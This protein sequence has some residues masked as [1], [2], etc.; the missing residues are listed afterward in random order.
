M[1]PLNRRRLAS[2][3][4]LALLMGMLGGC[5]GDPL[6]WLPESASPEADEVDE[7]IYLIIYVTGVVFLAVQGLLIWFLFRHRRKE[8]V[9]AK[10]THGN[11]TI[12]MVWTIAPALVL[13]LLAVYQADL[14]VRLK[15]KVP[16][17]AA[18]AVNVRIFAKQFE[19]NF[20]Y[21]GPDGEYDTADDLAT[22]G[23]LVMPIDRPVLAELRAMDVLHSFYLPNFRFKQDAVPGLNQE[24]WFRSNKLSADRDTVKNREGQDVQL[25]YWDIVCAELCGNAHTTMAGRCYVVSNADYEAWVA[26]E[27]T[28]VKLPGYS[29]IGA[30]GTSMGDLWT[31]WAWQDENAATG[32]PRWIKNKG[33]PFSGVDDRGDDE[34]SE[35]GEDDF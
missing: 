3:A 2:L 19:W 34:P 33:M 18:N 5:A 8:G 15:S 20:R 26:G 27:P 22:V 23:V 24:I 30:E 4:A 31:R 29:K 9:A 7:L 11:H 35:D 16:E 28:S 6:G 10:H 21:P 32:K 12:E 14:W 1:T 25:D 13:V 17:D